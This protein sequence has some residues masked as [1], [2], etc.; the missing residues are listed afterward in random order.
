MAPSLSRGSLRSR[1]YVAIGC[2]VDFIIVYVY[3]LFSAPS[4]G[5]AQTK[6]EDSSKYITAQSFTEDMVFSYILQE[7]KNKNVVYSPL[8]LKHLMHLLFQGSNGALH[9]KLKTL[10][11]DTPPYT[12]IES[13]MC[14]IKNSAWCTAEIEA[15]YQKKVN[16]IAQIFQIL[17]PLAASKDIDTWVNTQTKG[18]IE[19][20]GLTITP[21]TL[22]VLINVIYFKAQWVNAFSKS[23]T[24]PNKF[25]ALSG[26]KELPFMQFAGSRYLPYHENDDSKV[27]C[28]N[29]KNE[30]YSMVISF[31][32][33]KLSLLTLDQ[34]YE[35]EASTEP[36]DIDLL[37]PKF[38][39]DTDSNLLPILEKLGLKMLTE[40]GYLKQMNQMAYVSELKQVAKIIVDEE[41]TEAAAVTYGMISRSCTATPRTPLRIKL[42]R[43]FSYYVISKAQKEILFMGV[44]NG[45]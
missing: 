31:N 16:D 41:G 7:M 28:L 2:K 43:P 9:D 32:E 1:D 24:H 14:L 3:L 29:Y 34:V 23:R 44:F 18:L 30:L 20:L 13:G 6:Q 4:M 42:D 12:E 25:Y 33:K 8:G 17:D 36:C 26:T 37:M 27:I 35:R 40:T 21:A 11:M 10:S 39:I 22:M 15:D 38:T 19:K 45:N 5:T